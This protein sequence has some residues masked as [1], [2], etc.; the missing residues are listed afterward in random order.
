[1]QPYFKMKGRQM[2]ATVSAAVGDEGQR[3][4]SELTCWLDVACS[5]NFGFSAYLEVSPSHPILKSWT[6]GGTVWQ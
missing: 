3:G 5:P 6:A 4:F 1:M 2:A